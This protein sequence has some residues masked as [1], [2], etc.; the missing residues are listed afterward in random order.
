ME[1]AELN[2]CDSTLIL[3]TNNKY[4]AQ[5]YFYNNKRLK[6]FKDTD[7]SCSFLSFT[8]VNSKRY[9]VM[10]KTPDPS[11]HKKIGTGEIILFDFKAIFKKDTWKVKKVKVSKRKYH[12]KYL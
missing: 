4:I 5:D 9:K 1:E 8:E 3:A 12:A 7:Q 11:I 10:L 6:S 2:Y